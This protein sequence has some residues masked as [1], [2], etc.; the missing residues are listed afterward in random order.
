MKHLKELLCV[1]LA[2]A[3]PACGSEA[4]IRTNTG[5]SF[6]GEITGH[7]DG[8][9]FI[10]GRRI[11]KSEI[12][13]IDHP[14][15]VAAI[16]GTIVAGIGAVTA[17]KNCTAAQIELSKTP[18]QSSGVWMLTG[19]PIMIYGFVTHYESAEAAGE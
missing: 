16:L 12:R 14:G 5:A 1:L 11:S 8:G 17:T 15:N 10:N 13:D 4:I 19:I 3:V 9:V 2:L 6:E 18:C 7:D